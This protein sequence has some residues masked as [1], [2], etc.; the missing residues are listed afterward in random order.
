MTGD[1]SHYKHFESIL[2]ILPYLGRRIANVDLLAVLEESMATVSLLDSQHLQRYERALN[3][4]GANKN[5]KKQR[6]IVPRA[7]NR[8]EAVDVAAK[9][10][11][12]LWMNSGPLKTRRTSK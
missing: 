1:N 9:A 2:G 8:D 10:L 6:P 4:L 7:F 12:S 5:S 3:Q 11:A